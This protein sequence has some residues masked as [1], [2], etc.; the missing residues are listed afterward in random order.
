MRR[1]ERRERTA[2]VKAA[3]F[4]APHEEL[5]IEEVDVDAPADHEVLVRTAAS[6]V[7]HSDLHYIDGFYPMQAPAVLGHEA[8]GVVEAVGSQVTDFGPGDRVIACLSVFCGHCAQCLT[9]HPNLCEDR[10]NSRRGRAASTDLAGPT[11]SRRWRT[12]PAMPSRCCCTR[13]AS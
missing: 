10:P 5:T 11:A 13:T 6:G 7:C 8:A 12:S 3:I 4:H 2:R 1:T 9:G